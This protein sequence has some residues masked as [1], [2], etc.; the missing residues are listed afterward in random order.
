MNRRTVFFVSI[1][2]L[3][4]ASVRAQ[5]TSLASVDSNGVQGN[6]YSGTYGD[7]ISADGRFVAFGSGATN[8]VAGGSP[9][10]WEIFRHDRVTGSTVLASI[11]TSGVV[12]PA[13]SYYPSISA[14]G[15]AVAFESD[16][17]FN[18]GDTNGR[19]DVFV[20][21]F[22]AGTTTRMSVDS[23]GNQWGA[24][25]C[26]AAAISGDARFVAFHK[27]HPTTKYHHRTDVYV[28]DRQTGQTSVVNVNTSGVQ[29]A[30][31]YSTDP[32][33]SFD[34]RWIAFS[35]SATDL[36]S[37]DA[38][39]A[40]DVFLRDMQLGV[41]T[42]VSVDSSG[43]EGDGDSLD[44]SISSD[45]RFVAF[46]SVATNLAPGDLNAHAD[47]FVHDSLTGGTL[48]ASVGLNGV[49]ANADCVAPSISADG[50]F[51]SFQSSASNLV[52]GDTNN[53]AD[54]FVRDLLLGT[55]VR[56][57]L[58]VGGDSNGQSE[59]AHIS[60]DGR[61]IS[62]VSFASNLVVGDTNGT[63]DVF[64][65]DQGCT[66]ADFTY[67]TAKTNSLGC[68]PNIASSGAPSASAG[69]GFV[70]GAT[71]VLNNKSGLFFYSLAGRN[72]APFQGGTLCVKL[73]VART[74][75]QD[76]GGNPPP[77]DCSG[78]YTID[79]NAYIASGADPALVVG[80]IVDGQFWARD[81]GFSPPDN[82]SL[83]NAIEFVICE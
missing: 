48:L 45:G 75:L 53:Q 18:T 79:F 42:R 19:T 41:T 16:S 29:T 80:A 55:T 43:A 67:C 17:G 40:Y 9:L 69:S 54:V 7:A 10:Q 28:H 31:L 46:S 60:A 66:F 56:A 20:H 72:A 62:F 76:S 14:D 74:A 32:A 13:G 36:V 59:F 35:S 77:N 34:G 21:D 44:P 68:T 58:G 38:N 24:D 82:T 12:G 83:S 81:P 49:G 2:V 65:R 63:F 61:S 27:I 51:V 64:V 30:G 73:P 5:S 26:H 33:I 3:S 11:D 8:L 15:S 78:S 39:A 71:Q 50:R 6:N 52:A 23:N 37:G 25:S 22:V 70:V 1:A 4:A 57:S 47:V